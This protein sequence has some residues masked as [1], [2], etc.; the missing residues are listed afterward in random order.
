MKIR[1]FLNSI[2]ESYN[3]EFPHSKIIAE[4][5]NGLGKSI[6]IKCYMAGNTNEFINK[7]SA[8]DMFS[9]VFWYHDLPNDATLETEL[10]DSFV[11]ENTEKSYTIKPDNDYMCYGRRK[12]NYRKV[13]GTEKNIQA[14][15]K[16]FINLKKQLIKDITE[17][18]I[19]NNHIELLK[20]KLS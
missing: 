19:H 13:K 3:R 20:E 14:V 6:Y 2:Q 5:N 12:L 1:E 10:N 11:L 17:N 9:I 4:L 18:N 7:I 8:N 16:F 15:D